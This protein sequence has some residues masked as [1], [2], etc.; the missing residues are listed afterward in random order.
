MEMHKQ[1][2]LVLKI[3]D[4]KVIDTLSGSLQMVIFLEDVAFI[5]YWMSQ[6]STV[7]IDDTISFVFLIDSLVGFSS[8][9]V[10]Q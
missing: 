2:L 9:T 6:D 8:H 3:G 7:I 10:R 1:Q 5:L 4:K